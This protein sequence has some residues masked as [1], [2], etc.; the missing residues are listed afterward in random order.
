[1]IRMRRQAWIVNFFD[2]WMFRQEASNKIGI[3]SM[4]AHPH[5]QRLNTTQCQPSIER[6]WYSTSSIL[7]KLKCLIDFLIIHHH[8]STNDITMSID[9]FR[10]TMHNHIS[11]Q[12]KRL[13]E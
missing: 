3:L 11:T 8:H 4:L 1:M 5:S 12:I 6:S 13:L 7:V 2:P 10:G 9:I